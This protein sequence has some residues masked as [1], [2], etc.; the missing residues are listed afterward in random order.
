MLAARKSAWFERVFAAYNRN[1]LGRRFEGLRAAGLENLRERPRGLPLV[2]YANHSS[3]WDGLLAFQVGR[4]CDLDHYV[5]MEEEQLRAYAVFRRLGAFSVVREDAR[6]AARS[7]R[8][9]AGLLRGV[10]RAL[11]IFPQ[12]RIVPNDA[13]PLEL[14][15]GAAAV[16]RRAGGAY[17]APVA[18]RYEFLHDF[19]PE[20]FA[21]VGT[22]ERVA[23]GDGLDVL[24]SERLTRHFA[25]ALTRTLD[26]L[27]ADVLAEKFDGYEELVAPRR[28]REKSSGA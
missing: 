3:W 5:M 28:R 9:A 15:G 20:A 18:F 19:R 26:G 22:V 1:L 23:A 12:G 17:A 21:R 10:E 4:A 8:Y 14:Y 2:L 16:V 6:E 13:R 11:W 7:V 25:E 24:N 27:R